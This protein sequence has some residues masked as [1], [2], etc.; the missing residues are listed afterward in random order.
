MFAGP[1]RWGEFL[2][3]LA[4]IVIAFMAGSFTASFIAASQVENHIDA[5]I[6][7]TVEQAQAQNKPAS[8]AAAKLFAEVDSIC[9]SLEKN[10]QSG[11]HC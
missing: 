3:V 10:P 6:L 11:I 9:K 7:H 1:L 4:I 8:A 2:M 5:T